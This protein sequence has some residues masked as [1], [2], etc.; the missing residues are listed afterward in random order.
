MEEI[1]NHPFFEG[2]DWENIR[3]ESP[4]FLPK[5][6]TSKSIYTMEADEALHLEI[7]ELIKNKKSERPSSLR[8]SNFVNFEFLKNET[9]DSAERNLE[10][11]NRKI[12]R[13]KTYVHEQENRRESRQRK[14][15]SIEV[16][17]FNL[18]DDL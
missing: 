18:P 10:E 2:V 4:P 17:S 15:A 9:L 7:L 11:K 5:A 12:R 8:V 1:K 3:E 16:V 13:M 14:R 6:Q